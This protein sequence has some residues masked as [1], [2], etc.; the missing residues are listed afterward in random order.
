M[1][2]SFRI[3]IIPKYIVKIYILNSSSNSSFIYYRLFTCL[4]FAIAKCAMYFT[5]TSH[6]F[7]IT[8]NLFICILYA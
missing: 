8:I 3:F 2:H 4:S 7:L 6:I 1:Q 5:Y